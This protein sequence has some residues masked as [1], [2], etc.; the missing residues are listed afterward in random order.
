MNIAWNAWCPYYNESFTIADTITIQLVGGPRPNPDNIFYFKNLLTNKCS[1]NS[2]SKDLPK[3][4]SQ[5]ILKFNFAVVDTTVYLFI[6]LK[7]DNNLG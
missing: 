7:F 1:I 4:Q 2:F 5:F 6:S 3:E